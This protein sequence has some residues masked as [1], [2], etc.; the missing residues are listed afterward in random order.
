F[1]LFG[2]CLGYAAFAAN[3]THYRPL[4]IFFL[5]AVELNDVAAFVSGRLFGRR[6][7]CPNT[8][9]NKTIAG[10]IGALIATSAF[11]VI[12][13]RFVFAGTELEHFGRLLVLGIL[14][15]LAGTLGDLM[16][17]SIKRDVGIKDMDVL[18]PGHGG[19]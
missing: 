3:H 17:S 2:G 6:K 8:S 14:V 10:A 12:A 13:G 4:L 19:L 16:L 15:A 18:I 11:I 5:A 7:L 1:A 9:P